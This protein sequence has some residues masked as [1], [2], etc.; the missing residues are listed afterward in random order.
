M[1]VRVSDR[2]DSDDPIA[3]DEWQLIRVKRS[4][5]AARQRAEFDPEPPWPADK[6]A[7]RLHSVA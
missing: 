2:P 6:L 5:D 1:T 3:G 7:A 4:C